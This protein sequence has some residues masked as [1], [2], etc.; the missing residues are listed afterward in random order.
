MAPSLLLSQL[1]GNYSICLSAD[2]SAFVTFSGLLLQQ[3]KAAAA[4]AAGKEEKHA[5]EKVLEIVKKITARAPH[6][7]HWFTDGHAA[8]ALKHFADE[9]VRKFLKEAE[10][11]TEEGTGKKREKK[12]KGKKKRK[13]PKKPNKIIAAL[14]E[15]HLPLP[16]E[17]EQYFNWEQ[18]YS[19][20]T[21]KG[22]EIKAAAAA[23]AEPAAAA[24]AEQQHTLAAAAEHLQTANGCYKT[25]G[26][27][28][29]QLQA[30][31]GTQPAADLLLQQAESKKIHKDFKHMLWRVFLGK[32][33]KP[34]ALN[35][36]PKTLNPKP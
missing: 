31:L 35:L 18:F 11:E 3:L 16:F 28:L 1:S 27:L 6:V 29:Q 2:V 15:E 19:L 10:K 5:K 4:A 9:D 24:A 12:E 36:N 13:K 33:L 30:V 34:S 23:A 26:K 17:L 22:D 25:G 32:K 20:Y 21:S 8:F 14:T 7:T